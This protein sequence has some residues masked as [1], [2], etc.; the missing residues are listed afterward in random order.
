MKTTDDSFVQIQDVTKRFGSVLAVD[1]ADLAIR[2]GEFFSLLGPSG[3]GKTTLLRLLA[4]FEA[5]TTGA[6]YI[7][8]DEMS[9]V[10]AFRR[11]TSM[12]FQ[13]YA[14]FPHLDVFNNVAFGLR[15]KGLSS[16]ELKQKVH[17]ALSGMKLDGFENRRANQLSGGQRQRVALARSLVTEPKLLLLDEPLGALDKKLREEMQIELRQLQQRVGITFV[18]VTHDQEEALTLS[19]RIAVMNE[20][21][22][23]QVATPHELYERPASRAVAEFIGQM[24]LL[25]VEVVDIEA[26][27][28]TVSCPALGENKVSVG[29]SSFRCGQRATLAVRPENLVL[30]TEVSEGTARVELKASAYYGNT[31]IYRVAVEGITGETIDISQQDYRGSTTPGT[32]LWLRW[33]SANFLLLSE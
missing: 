17:D 20:G 33:D 12:V 6:I 14:I 10:P 28:V 13:S 21:Q 31:T 16:P 27:S 26:D 29:S 3:C 15:G 30:D 19:D 1:Q 4:G 24:N 22:I 23:L 32:I 8:G 7:D 9:T 11:P 2:R 5:P 25:E 18:F